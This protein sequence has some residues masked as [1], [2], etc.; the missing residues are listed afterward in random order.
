MKITYHSHS[1]VQIENDSF[2]ILIDPFISGNPAS[3]ISKD[4]ISK[5]DYIILT[6]GHGDHY[7][8]TE[9]LAKKFGATVIATFELAGYATKKGL[10]S[11]PLNIG[12]GYNF[13]FGRVR[14]TMAH[15]SSS[16]IDGNYAGESAGVLI[17]MDGKVIY[18][19]GDTCL[20]DDMKNIGMTNKIDYAFLPIGDNFTMGVD[21]A[22]KAVEY[23]RARVT[24]PIHY[25]TFEVIKADAGDFCRKVQSIGKKCLI[26]NPEDIINI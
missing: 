7:G 24:V 8:D 15:H 20:F 1:F 18:H 23:I 19:A 26:M 13:P 4:D 22:V 5:C 9:Y 6:H 25:N 10:K 2:S 3:K 21:E 11:H 16:T 14:L 12:G 17:H